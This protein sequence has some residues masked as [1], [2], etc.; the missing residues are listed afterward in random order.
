MKQ[1]FF[2]FFKT[3]RYVVDTPKHLC[4]SKIAGKAV[5]VTISM[6]LLKHWSASQR[7]LAVQRRGSKKILLLFFEARRLVGLQ[8][9]QSFERIGCTHYTA[10][11]QSVTLVC[12]TWLKSI[13]RPSCT[14][15]NI[16][17]SRLRS[18]S[19]VYDRSAINVALENSRKTLALSNTRRILKSDVDILSTS[20]KGQ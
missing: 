10:L 13:L 9:A 15:I 14:S 3:E 11:G 12:C 19:L 2:A 5:E 16:H 7:S 17:L 8:Y 18:F 20:L 1:I 6:L 4:H